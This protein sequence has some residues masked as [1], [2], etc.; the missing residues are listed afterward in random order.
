MNSLAKKV[1]LATRCSVCTL[2]QKMCR[3]ADLV[4]LKTW[5]VGRLNFDGY[6]TICQSAGYDQEMPAFYRLLQLMKA[7]RCLSSSSTMVGLCSWSKWWSSD[8]SWTSP[9]QHRE[10]FVLIFL[11]TFR[12]RSHDLPLPLTLKRSRTLQLN[13]EQLDWGP[14]LINGLFLLLLVM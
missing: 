13:H 3:L 7:S 4:L 8:N 2:M 6:G 14:Q 12:W 1:L 11:L 5:W 10:I 9:G